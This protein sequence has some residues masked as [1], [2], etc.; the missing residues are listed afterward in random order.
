MSS[1][2][3][4]RRSCWA[5]VRSVEIMVG[6]PWRGRGRKGLGGGCG[7]QTGS[8]GASPPEASRSPSAV[9]SA[10]PARPGQRG[11]PPDFS[12]PSSRPV[13]G[14]GQ[15][16]HR[17]CGE[18]YRHPVATRT[19]RTRTAGHARG[20]AARTVPPPHRTARTPQRPAASTP[21]AE[22]RTVPTPVRVLEREAELRHVD[23][24]LE[25]SV[26]GSGSLLVIE[27]PA[28]IGTSA[29]LGAARELARSRG[30]Q[31]LTAR[32]AEL[33]RDFAFGVAR[34]LLEPPLAALTADAGVLRGPAGDAARTLALPG[35]PEAGPEPEALPPGAPFA[36]LHGLYRLCAQLAEP[37]PLVLAVDD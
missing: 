8:P 31:V 37:A 1:S 22:R 16:Y 30:L 15:P 6:G 24:A 9:Q 13:Q 7:K 25:R 35:A 36:V 14:C 27:G 28:G 2:S 5:R 4:G 12:R 23:A 21:P 29:L 18:P 33:E 20:V 17:A 11:H 19:I 26:A 3:A 10:R 32:G 34:Q